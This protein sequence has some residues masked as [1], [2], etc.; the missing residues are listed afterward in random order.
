MVAG[1]FRCVG[2]IAGFVT[3]AGMALAQSEEHPFGAPEP[4][5][6]R[7]ADVGPIE[8]V[9]GMD[10][11]NYRLQRS[12]ADRERLDRSNIDY[13]RLQRSNSRSFRSPF[14]RID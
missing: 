3:L 14:G 10:R 1:I 12:N 8:P 6:D 4:L 11:D 5:P 2:F 13:D 7:P 9:E